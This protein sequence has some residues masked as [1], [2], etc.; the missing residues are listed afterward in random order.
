VFDNTTLYYVH[1]DHLDRPVVMTNASAMT[2][3][4]QAK[5]DPFGVPVAVT[6]S[7]VNNQRLPGQWFQSE[8]GLAYN[9]HRTYDPTLGRYSQADPLGFVDGPNI[10]NY[11]AA[12]PLMGLDPWGLWSLFLGGEGSGAI[13]FGGYLSGGALYDSE[14]GPFGYG[15]A[16]FTT[17]LGASLSGQLGFFTGNACDFSGAGV[18]LSL[19]LG[20][21]FSLSVLRSGGHFGL[22]LG[23]GAS[24]GLFGVKYKANAGAGYTGIGALGGAPDPGGYNPIGDYN[25]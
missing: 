11:A 22:A 24:A 7:P 9:W 1:P 5:Y 4:W 18:F 15:S 21:G 19:P 2:I 14:N 23:Y 20:K 16:G 3:A 25:G 12:N 6:V 8:D 10:Y 17:G 13:G